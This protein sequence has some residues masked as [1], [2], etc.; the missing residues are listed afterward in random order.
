VQQHGFAIS[1]NE[2]A[3]ERLPDVGHEAAAACV[4]PPH[5]QF[6]G[7]LGHFRGAG[8]IDLEP[9]QVGG[10]DH[11]VRLGINE[12]GAPRF[13]LIIEANDDQRRRRGRRRSGGGGSA[14]V[15]S[16]GNLIATPVQ[17]TSARPASASQPDSSFKRIACGSVLLHALLKMEASAPPVPRIM[18][19]GNQNRTT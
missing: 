8:R 15:P 10:L 11:E 3:I 19:W 13:L 16:S 1:Y 18:G 4:K 9:H 5:G 12:P 7:G 17:R 2:V 6:L 14:P